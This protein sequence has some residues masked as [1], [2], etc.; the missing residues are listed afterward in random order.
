MCRPDRG[1]IGREVQIRLD[2]Y[3]QR[4]NDNRAN[5]CELAVPTATRWGISLMAAKKKSPETKA[6]GDNY[7][8][9]YER[10]VMYTAPELRL[11]RE[12]RRATTLAD[13]E[14]CDTPSALFVAQDQILF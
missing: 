14:L 6:N 13:D 10:I 1:I 2:C 11:M 7:W 8:A 9:C 12:A 3:L 4:S 5:R